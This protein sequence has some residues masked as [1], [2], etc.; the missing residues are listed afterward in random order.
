MQ[1]LAEAQKIATKASKKESVL[2]V[3]VNRYFTDTDGNEVNKAAV[4][5]AM[6][7]AYPFYL[8]GE[9]DRVG[10]Y[11]QGNNLTPP[12]VGSE[13]VGT[14]MIGEGAPF[15]GFNP[16]NTIGSK[17]KLGDLAHVY[18]DS[19]A[20]PTYYVFIVQGAQ[21]VSLLSVLANS[22]DA[23][24]FIKSFSYFTDN[25]DQWYNELNF[26]SFNA[27][28]EYTKDAISPF[29]S[30]S[31]ELKS[32]RGKFIL[33]EISWSFTQY[34]EIASYMSFDTDSILFNFNVINH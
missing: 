29:L 3:Y 2:S 10:G 33:A 26:I 18:T 25:V 6:Q 8:L 23:K 22:R 14:F 20:L 21:T 16:L 32:A 28:G 15:L 24:G 11:K 13:Y 19:L 1:Q 9:F 4:P 27:A 5:A 12:L 31:P 34:I 17:L 30:L 7:I